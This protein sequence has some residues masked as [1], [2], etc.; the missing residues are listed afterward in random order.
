MFPSHTCVLRSILAAVQRKKLAGH[1]MFVHSGD[2]TGKN[3][4]VWIRSVLVA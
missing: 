3:E 2:R 4:S 1:D